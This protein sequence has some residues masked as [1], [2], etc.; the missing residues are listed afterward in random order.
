[1]RER[2]ARLRPLVL[3]AGG[4]FAGA[5]LRYALAGALPAGALPWGTLAANV[6][7]AFL[8]SLLLYENRLVGSLGPETR[9]L[10]GTGFCSSFTTYSTFAVE[11][12]GLAGLPALGTGA[13]T[14]ALA[15]GYVVFTYVLG[16]VGIGLGQAVAR[17]MA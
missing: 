12:A 11:T 9:L 1:M 6:A 7:G 16:F 13:S 8:L 10:V 2:L 4:G 3:V 17:V 14:P 15:V 5:T